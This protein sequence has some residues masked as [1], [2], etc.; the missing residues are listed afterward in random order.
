VYVSPDD[1][2]AEDV[3]VE[4]VLVDSEHPSVGMSKFL[5]TEIVAAAADDDNYD[6]EEQLCIVEKSDVERKQRGCTAPDVDIAVGYLEAAV[7]VCVTVPSRDA[8]V[9]GFVAPAATVGRQYYRMDRGWTG[10]DS[11]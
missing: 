5:G 10:L 7:V 2:V 1:V 6:E 4:D 11:L 8:A 9:D 3:G